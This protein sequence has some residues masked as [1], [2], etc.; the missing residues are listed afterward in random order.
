MFA[1]KYSM[2]EKNVCLQISLTS[3]LSMGKFVNLCIRRTFDFI[4]KKHAKVDGMSRTASTIS[5]VCLYY[6]GHME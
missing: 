3:M 5:S 6:K 2:E 1:P 4:K